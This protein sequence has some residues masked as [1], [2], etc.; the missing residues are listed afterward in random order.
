MRKL[1]ILSAFL[2]FGTF[3][4]AQTYEVNAEKST[5]KWVGKKIASQHNGTVALKEGNF[6]IKDNKF[7]SGT[8]IIDLSIMTDESSD[9]PKKPSRLVGHLK[10]E[11][12]FSVDK[13]PVAKLEIISS[14]KFVGEKSKVTGKLTIKD[15]THPINFVVMRKG[16]TFTSSMEFDRTLYDIKYGSGKFF[17]DIGDKAIKDEVGIDVILIAERQR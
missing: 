15:K 10:S 1:V 13:Y 11:D 6:E 14:E 4:Y 9:D 16:A 12:F 2:V 3:L 8:F 17:Q 7:V 5:V